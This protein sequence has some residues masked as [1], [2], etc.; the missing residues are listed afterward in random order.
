MPSNVEG[1]PFYPSGWH[2]WCPFTRVET[3]NT[4]REF[5]FL[6]NMLPS[7]KFGVVNE[8]DNL[9]I[10]IPNQ[11]TSLAGIGGGLYGVSSF[12][13]AGGVTTGTSLVIILSRKQSWLNN[14]GKTTEIP[15]QSPRFGFSIGGH[16]KHQA[17]VKLVVYGRGFVGQGYQI[18]WLEAYGIPQ[19]ELTTNSRLTKFIVHH[20]KVD[21]VNKQHVDSTTENPEEDN[22]LVKL[23]D[24]SFSASFASTPSG[25]I[26]F[27]GLRGDGY[28]SRTFDYTD[29]NKDWYA[30]IAD[31]SVA[32][33]NAFVPSPGDFYTL[34]KPIMCDDPQLIHEF[35]LKLD[36]SGMYMT[37]DQRWYIDNH[38]IGLWI[39][40]TEMAQDVA[41]V[42][43]DKQSRVRLP[44]SQAQ[45]EW[46]AESKQFGG[47]MADG[48]ELWKASEPPL[49]TVRLI[50]AAQGG[51][52]TQNYFSNNLVGEYICV[53]GVAPRDGEPVAPD[54]WYEIVSHPRLDTIEI[55]NIG[56]V[57][58]T[59]FMDNPTA[60]FVTYQQKFW[61]ITELYSGFGAGSVG[62][63]LW[64]GHIISMEKSETDNTCEINWT[65][66]EYE[67][68]LFLP[69][70]EVKRNGISTLPE[71]FRTQCPLIATAIN[72]YDKYAGWLAVIDRSEYKIKSI[73]FE[74]SSTSTIQVKVVV[75]GNPTEQSDNGSPVYVTLGEP[76]KSALGASFGANSYTDMRVEIARTIDRTATHAAN[77]SCIRMVGTYQSGFYE[78][79]TAIGSK[80][81]IAIASHSYGVESPET[82]MGV[83]QGWVTT[84]KS[85]GSAGVCYVEHGATKSRQTVFYRDLDLDALMSVSADTGWIERRQKSIIKLGGSP[86][87]TIASGVPL[88]DSYLTGIYAK[89]DPS[90]GS[91]LK[92]LFAV[93]PVSETSA[94]PYYSQKIQGYGGI[95][96]PLT[97]RHNLDI[98][99]TSVHPVELP[100][101]VYEP[102]PKTNPPEDAQSIFGIP[103]AAKSSQV[104]LSRCGFDEV[105]TGDIFTRLSNGEQ[106]PVVTPSVPATHFEFTKTSQVIRSP[107]LSNCHALEDGTVVLFYGA[108]SGKFSVFGTDN[109]T[110]PSKPCVFVV[111]SDTNVDKWGSP[112]YN[113]QQANS[114]DVAIAA[115]WERPMMLA[116]DFVFAGSVKITT[117]QFLIFG[118]GYARNTSGE[119]MGGLNYLFLGCYLVSLS[120][121]RA[122]TTHKCYQPTG[123][124]SEEEQ[125]RFYFRNNNAQASS[126]MYE[127]E[128]GQPIEGV[129]ADVSPSPADTCPERFTKIIGGLDSG[130][131]ISEIDLSQEVVAPVAAEDGTL[132][133]YLRDMNTDKIMRIW[134]CSGGGVW[135]IETD[136]D[137][138]IIYYASG[139]SPTVFGRLLFYFAGDALYCKNLST[140]T[141]GVYNTK[142]EELDKLNVGIVATNVVG[143]KIAVNIDPHGQVFVFYLNK[144]GDVCASCSQTSGS[145][146]TN[147]PN[148]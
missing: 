82:A 135:K 139:S 148:W 96:T 129:P 44:S 76:Y 54:E 9:S 131:M 130:A 15:M 56:I 28:Q 110:N 39:Y 98:S 17:Y 81:R 52:P 84:K 32:E 21:I 119:P 58:G 48:V 145:T 71:R 6:P 47:N 14:G 92:G 108:D 2:P 19:I 128:F 26:T 67:S 11:D 104:T 88:W 35:D 118:Y 60:S 107:K 121:M 79:S 46:V 29:I 50:V 7:T 77:Q 105:K 55:N 136:S 140:V 127:M 120:G 83:P 5:Y 53:K 94:S 75:E 42:D 23:F 91:K 132:S 141:E 109:S 51:S 80:E 8:Y 78:L 65:T 111:K 45:E 95:M 113:N 112:K 87:L 13:F 144:S 37:K 85:S 43:S 25:K 106:L 49:T 100:F 4:E 114:G 143:H 10:E 40:D 86:I 146:W 16:F 133:V 124:S 122:G 70:F 137:G 73:T 59:V 22:L 93:V 102:V 18:G 142:Q 123:S 20:G 97:R 69:E 101:E 27:Y 147:L 41:Y 64:G 99:S 90:V 117:D 66:R 38:G 125:P 116:Y 126:P 74:A 89:M 72:G 57:N 31:P 34:Y 33:P 30:K 68:F 103:V 36:P 1:L 3:L 61:K 62:G 138:K 63:A 12:I 24:N 115:E 134:S